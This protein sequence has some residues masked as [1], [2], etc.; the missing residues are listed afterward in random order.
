MKME[1]SEVKSG[2]KVVGTVES[3][4]YDT[5]DEAV[6]AQGA[7]TVLE[8]FNRQTQTDIRDKFRSKFNRPT[9]TTALRSE[10][11][12][13]LMSPEGREALSDIQT[14]V[15]AGNK[16]AFDDY[17]DERVEKLKTERGLD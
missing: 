4:R 13:W 10:I 12:M 5:I 1:M 15:V 17:V 3:P 11:T 9:S 7:E 8:R 2:G 6:L 16:S 14:K